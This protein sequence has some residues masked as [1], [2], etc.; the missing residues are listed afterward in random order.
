MGRRHPNPR[1][2]KIHRNY[3]VEEVARLFGIHKNT[4]RGWLKRGLPAIDD[5]RPTLILGQE[6]SRF[7]RERRQKEKQ[8][9]GPGRIF[10]AIAPARSSHLLM[11]ALSNEALF[12]WHYPLVEPKWFS[13]MG[14]KILPMHSELFP[15]L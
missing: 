14:G 4:V 8:R 12:D 9:C 15:I 1:R 10:C 7:L 6:L 11:G 5:R 2:V 13:A 3:S